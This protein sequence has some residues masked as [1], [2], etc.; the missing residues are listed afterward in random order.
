MNLSARSWMMCANDGSIAALSGF[1]RRF[2]GEAR[3]Y[4][5]KLSKAKPRDSKGVVCRGLPWSCFGQ[6]FYLPDLDGLRSKLSCHSTLSLTQVECSQHQDSAKARPTDVWRRTV[7]SRK[8]DVAQ[9]ANRLHDS[10]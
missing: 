1:V 10:A 7:V 4:R 6:R 9:S 8:A 5:G 3:A 2:K